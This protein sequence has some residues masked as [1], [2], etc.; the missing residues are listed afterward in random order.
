M[1]L[2]QCARGRHYERL[3]ETSREWHFKI[4]R[5]WSH[6][7][8]IEPASSRPPTWDK[9][10]RIRE[11]LQD[12]SDGEFVVYLDCDAIIRQNI[13]TVIASAMHGADFGAVENV[14][15][16]FNGGMTI[17]QANERTRRCARVIDEQGPDM[18][19]PA[20]EQE[21]VDFYVRRQLRCV[22]LPRNWNDYSAARGSLAAEPVYIRAWHGI[23]AADALPMM[24][25][26]L[27]DLQAAA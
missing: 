1:I 11:A 14:W 10:R 8:Y 9:C 13:A 17:W 23:G 12:A 24:E 2:I 4:L 5:G 16:F 3:I 20:Q 27:A 6:R 22:S 7:I 25:R 19:M 15:G 26:E 18:R 21:T